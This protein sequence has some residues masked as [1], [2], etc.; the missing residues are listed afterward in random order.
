MPLGNWSLMSHRTVRIVLDRRHGRFHPPREADEERDAAA[1]I[2]RPGGCRAWSGCPGSP[3]RPALPAG[4]GAVVA[5]EVRARERAADAQLIVSGPALTNHRISCAAD[6]AQHPSLRKDC[7]EHHPTASKQA[8][9][10]D[11]AW[12]SVDGGR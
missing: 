3:V 1:P 9:R 2:I 8:G 12:M 4:R 7:S 10:A 5:G 6:E 11:G